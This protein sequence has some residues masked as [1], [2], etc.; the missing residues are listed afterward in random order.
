MLFSQEHYDLIAQFEKIYPK[1][2]RVS[3]RLDREDKALWAS[4]HIYQHT[5]TNDAFLM[6]RLGY[7]FG[8]TVGRETA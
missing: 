3:Y 2:A 6:Y 5:P 8:V 4:G 7:S 1:Y